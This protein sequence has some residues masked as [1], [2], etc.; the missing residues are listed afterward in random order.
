MMGTKCQGACAGD[1]VGAGDSVPGTT[2][3]EA[4]LWRPC[5]GDHVPVTTAG[6]TV[7]G[8]LGTVPSSSSSSSSR[9]CGCTFLAVVAPGATSSLRTQEMLQ[10]AGR[11][12]TATLA[13]WQG[14]GHLGDG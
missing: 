13:P 5:A 9:G 4:R 10:G 14:A 1:H 11:V 2:C 7:L 3:W 8:T 6:D 12:G